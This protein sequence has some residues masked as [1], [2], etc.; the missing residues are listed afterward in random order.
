VKYRFL[1]DAN[2]SPELEK[3]AWAREHEAYHVRTLGR[4]NDGDPVLLKL[5]EA[6]GYTLVTNNIVE[7]RARYRN[8]QVFHAG[9]VFIAEASRGR[10]FQVGAFEKTLDHI[11]AHGPI[12]NM[13]ILVESDPA[14]VYKVTAN[15]LP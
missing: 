8:R 15:Q 10:A 1:I 6:E 11:A 9:V 14:T 4:E 7:F 13:E 2:V 12:D 5:I 3:I